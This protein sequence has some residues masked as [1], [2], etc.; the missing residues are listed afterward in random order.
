MISNRVQTK[1]FTTDLKR[2]NLITVQRGPLAPT[3]FQR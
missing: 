3:T 1:P 2:F